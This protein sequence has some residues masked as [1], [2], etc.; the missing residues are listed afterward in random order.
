MLWLT[1]RMQVRQ[2]SVRGGRP[3]CPIDRTHRVHSHGGYKR[4][5][6]ADGT[7][8]ERVPRWLCV[9]CGGTISV[10]PDTLLPYRPVG[11]DLLEEWFDAD[12]MG[13]AP[14]KVTENEKGCL[15]R[16]LTRFLQRIPSLT[17]VLGQMIE[18]LSPTATH[19]WVRLRKLGKL[20]EI[21]RFLAEKFKTSLLGDYRCLQPWAVS[22]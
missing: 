16:A 5:G 21:L 11:A 10:L 17:E 4:Y 7:D 15:E 6:K 3:E 13:R 1:A 22:G 19:L 2:S 20:T 12:F 18:I 8:K 14:P 9:V